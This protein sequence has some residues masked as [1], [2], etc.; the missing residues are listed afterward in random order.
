[1]LLCVGAIS[2]RKV[3]C[4]EDVTS[5]HRFSTKYPILAHTSIFRYPGYMHPAAHTTHTALLCDCEKM[6]SF[7]RH[8]DILYIWLLK[9]I[10]MI[11]ERYIYTFYLS[12]KT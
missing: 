10:Y 12:D 6:I 8:K 5:I 4:Y 2:F 1:M 11:I 9:D 3:L 7:Q